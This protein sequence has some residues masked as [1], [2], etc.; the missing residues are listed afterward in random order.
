MYQPSKC[1]LLCFRDRDLLQAKSIPIE[2]VGEMQTALGHGQ[3]DMRNAGDHI[4]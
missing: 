3:V 1:V 2:L 4:V